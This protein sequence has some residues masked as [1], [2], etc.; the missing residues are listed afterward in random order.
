[1]SEEKEVLRVTLKDGSMHVDFNDKVNM[2]LASHA[3]RLASLQLDNAIC[4]GNAPLVQT[5]LPP[6]ITNRLRGDNGK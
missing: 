5:H 2:A 1:M 3:L 6:D 4:K